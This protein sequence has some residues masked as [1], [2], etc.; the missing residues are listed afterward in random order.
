MLSI[1]IVGLSPFV[2]A[3]MGGTL[4]AMVAL[5]LSIITILDRKISIKKL[6][7]VMVVVLAG[8]LLVAGIDILFNPNP[9]HAGK[10]IR[11]LL[12]GGGFNKLYEII[13]IKLRQVFWNLAYASWNIVLFG[14]II[15]GILLFK[16]KKDDI[17]NLRERYKY[18]F[19]GF[20]IILLTSLAVF[21]FNDTGTIAAALVLIYL[22]IPLGIFLN[23]EE[24]L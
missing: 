16:F 22:F 10:A 15:L 2:G 9:T 4:S 11:A 20:T 19:K 21:A 23:E 24:S 1:I 17:L 3:N 13:S 14:E 12:T 18:I 6:L 5:F 7:I 8:I